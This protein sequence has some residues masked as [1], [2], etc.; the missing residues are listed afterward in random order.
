MDDALHRFHTF[1]DELLLGRAR[2]EAKVKANGLRIERLKKPTVNEKSKAETSTLSKK[3]RVMNPW[4]YF[5]SYEIDVS[6]E[7]DAY[8]DYLKIHMMSH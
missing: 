6:N 4:R 3:Q 8:L 5:I 1:K 2:K 7:L